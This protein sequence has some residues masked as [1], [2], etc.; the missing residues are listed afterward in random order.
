VEAEAFMSMVYG[1]MIT[2]RAY[3]DPKV[4][5]DIVENGLKRLVRKA[6]KVA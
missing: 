4:F 6:G 5:S 3:G 2:A 1:A